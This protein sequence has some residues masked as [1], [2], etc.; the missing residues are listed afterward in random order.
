MTLTAPVGAKS[1]GL[2]EN[3]YYYKKNTQVLEFQTSEKIASDGTVELAF[4]H[5]FDYTI[6]IDE[7]SHELQTENPGETMITFVDVQENDWF[8]DA[9]SYAEE[10][11]LMSGMSQRY[12]RTQYS[13]D[14][15]NAGGCVL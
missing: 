15:R 14:Q 3:L 1:A 12:F 4:S 6:V 2:G 11:G 10:N 13:F 8:Y 9:V 5:V 7:E